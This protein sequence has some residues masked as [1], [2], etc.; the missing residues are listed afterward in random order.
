MVVAVL[1]TTWPTALLVS[2]TIFSPTIELLS[3][4]NPVANSNLSKVGAE[5][6]VDS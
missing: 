5:E 6:S 4:A 3:N 1:L 2:P